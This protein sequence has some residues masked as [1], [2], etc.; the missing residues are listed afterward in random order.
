M[1]RNEDYYRI[2]GYRIA[3]RLGGVGSTDLPGESSIGNRL[4]EVYLSQTVPDGLL[5]LSAGEV[6][7]YGKGF[8]LFSEVLV[9]LVF[10]LSAGV[11][12]DFDFAWFVF[13]GNISP[14][15]AYN[16]TGPI[17]GGVQPS[18]RY[19][20]G[21]DVEVSHREM[22]ASDS[23]FSQACEARVRRNSGIPFPVRAETGIIS[24]P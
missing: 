1:T 23:F 3:Y 21:M 11:F 18:Q 17:D 15:E 8:A 7:G 16:G 5:K 10:E 9:E 14:G 6:D 22:V 4:S 20:E 12:I 13:G 24:I 19:V 2:D